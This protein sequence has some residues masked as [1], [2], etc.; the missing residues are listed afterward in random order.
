MH[1]MLQEIQEQPMVVERILQ[2][3]PRI[4]RLARRIRRRDPWFVVMAARGTSDNAALYGKYLFE[5]L[6][7]LPVSLAAPSVI[8]LY[9]SRLRL[10]KSLV[11][12][13]SQSGESL[14]IVE[15]LRA[16]RRLGALT[17]A[18][19]N[20]ERSTLARNAH[21]VL[22]CYA[23]EER[24]I[25]ATKTYM[26]QLTV[27]AF[28]AATWGELGDLERG[29]QN[30]PRALEEVL[31]RKEEIAERVSRYRYM[32]ECI[33]SARG[34]NYATAKEAALKLKETCYVLAEALSSADLLH[35]PIAIV[36]RDFPVFL[37]APTG[38]AYGHLLELTERLVAQGAEVV[39][40]SDAQ[41]ILKKGTVPI[42]VPVSVPEEVTP[43]VL[44]I[45]AQLFA[46]H[47]ALA[48]GLDPD[49]PRGLRK[50]TRTL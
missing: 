29:L 32:G 3:S 43:H 30:L 45:P 47:L 24:S 15:F 33:V 5:T 34:Y 25:A 14:D 17:V 35:G 16:A 37:F 40:F 7:G 41:E 1:F 6:L 48:K 44:I 13:I 10:Q 46:Y 21:E 12:G 38:K 20:H 26:G 8:T 18:I 28:L 22:L 19:T 42:P 9:S 49:Y 50:I 23:G 39:V 27:L 31:K 11:L 36:E 4:R 2:E